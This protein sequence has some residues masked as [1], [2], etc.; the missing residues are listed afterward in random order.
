[1]RRRKMLASL[2]LILTVAL[3]LAG[4]RGL[5]PDRAGGSGVAQAADGDASA[6][7]ALRKAG[8]GYVEAYNKGDLDALLAFWAADGDYVDAQGQAHKGQA[9]LRALYKTN[10]EHFKGWKLTGRIVGLRFLKPDVALEDGILELAGPGGPPH[11]G[12]YAAVWIKKDDRW[13]ISSARDVGGEPAGEAPASAERLKEL[14]WLVGEWTHADE[15]GK[16]T[17]ACRW[18]PNKSFLIQEFQAQ[19]KDAEPLTV[20]QWVGWDPVE[21]KIHSWFFDS[22]GGYGQS[23]WTRSGNT[24]KAE[25]DGVT[26][27]GR[28]GSSVNNLKFVDDQSFHW[29]LTDRQ[30]DGHPMPDVEARLVRK[31]AN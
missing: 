12:R 1:M 27:D 30:L 25:G 29:H 28:I 9:A 10:L 5:L 16:I 18:A 3:T 31:A 7:A 11:V 22:H 23:L 15:P 24:W 21:G 14:Q 6:E 19:V 13:V 4:V 8:Q 20:T 26:P 2:F 17:L